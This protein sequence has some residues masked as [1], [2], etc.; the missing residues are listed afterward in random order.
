[1]GRREHAQRRRGGAA[2]CAVHT[3]RDAAQV[4]R[5]LRLLLPLL[6]LHQLLRRH[7]LCLLRLRLQAGGPG[8]G[9]PRQLRRPR[10]LGKQVLARAGI[11]REHV[12]GEALLW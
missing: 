10:R 3:S 1:M 2:G 9:G 11:G 12:P 7:Q 6:L 5:L 8:G 4:L